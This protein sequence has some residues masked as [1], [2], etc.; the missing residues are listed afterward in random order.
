M[1]KRNPALPEEFYVYVIRD[2]ISMV[3][4]TH[5]M[6]ATPIAKHG[7]AACYSTHL[8]KESA[9]FYFDMIRNNYGEEELHK[10]EKVMLFFAT[11]Q[12]RSQKLKAGRKHGTKGRYVYY[13]PSR[14]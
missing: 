7:L 9:G 11:L 12:K 4:V 6:S 2:H 3:T 8:D 5:A 14:E 13:K 1:S 10:I